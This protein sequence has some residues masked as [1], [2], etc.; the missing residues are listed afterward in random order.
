MNGLQPPLNKE[1]L[2]ESELQPWDRKIGS[3]RVSSE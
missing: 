3:I 1:E 2:P